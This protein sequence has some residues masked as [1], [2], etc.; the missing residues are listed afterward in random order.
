MLGDARG[1]PR[2]RLLSASGALPAA[3]HSPGA[4]GLPGPTLAP[5]EGLTAPPQSTCLPMFSLPG[6][7]WHDST[8][9]GSAGQGGRGPL[10]GEVVKVCRSEMP[11]VQRVHE[12]FQAKDVV[13]LAISI[14]GSGEKAVKS[15]VTKRGYTFH[16]PGGRA[17]GHSPAIRG[18]WRP[19][20]LC[21]QSAG[22]DCGARLRAGRF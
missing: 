6:C 10:L 1:Q 18:A 11:S 22:G 21:H 3:L 2:L 17:D 15:F 7:Q 13:V 8:G 4:C 9:S 14:D 5:P 16:H 19:D 12:A 20:H